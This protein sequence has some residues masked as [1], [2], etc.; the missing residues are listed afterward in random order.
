MTLTSESSLPITGAGVMPLEIMDRIHAGEADATLTLPFELRRKSRLL[1]RL[2]SGEPARLLLPRGVTLRQGDLLQTRC[3]RVVRVQA[4][5][6]IVST[7][8]APQPLLLLRAAYHLGNR[9]VPLEIA[10]DRLRYPHDPV[11]DA[12]LEQLGLSVTVEQAP[13]EPESG[14]YGGQHYQHA[15]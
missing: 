15:H 6:E 13:F 8:V 14:A 10:P 3:G 9:H 1:T 4:A 2:D 11:L 5:Q 12:M 7:A